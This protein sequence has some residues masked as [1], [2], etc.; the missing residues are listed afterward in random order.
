MKGSI[1]CGC[2]FHGIEICTYHASSTCLSIYPSSRPSYP[3]SARF[4]GP[5]YSKLFCSPIFCYLSSDPFSPFASCP[6]CSSPSLFCPPCS[7]FDPCF[8]EDLAEGRSAF[9]QSPPGG[10][11]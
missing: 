8:P 6:I 4:S 2:T 1:T 10:W 9:F 7:P 3:I 11:I 5:Y